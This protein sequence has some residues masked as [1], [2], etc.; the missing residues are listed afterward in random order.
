MAKKIQ[1]DINELIENWRVKTNTLANQV[2]ELDNLGD[3]AAN[4]VAAIVA[5]QDSSNTGPV[6]TRIQSM[7]DS[8]N[9]LRFPVVTVDIKDSAVTTAKIKDLNVTT[10]KFA[11][12]AVDSNAIGANAIHAQ[13]IDNDQIVNR[14]YA[15]SSIDAAFIKQNQITSREFNGLT[16][17]T[18]TSDS[19]TTLKSIFGPGS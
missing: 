4:I 14:H 13:H 18:I 5:L 17:F 10:A 9:T 16:T 7:I 1:V 6:T 12:D 3:S 2:G 8:N 15:D 19:G 11:A